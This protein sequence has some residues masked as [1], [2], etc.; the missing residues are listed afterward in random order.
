MLVYTPHSR[1]AREA[2]QYAG[3]KAAPR[4]IKNCDREV[5]Q[6]NDIPQHAYNNLRAL[7]ENLC[8]LGG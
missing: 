3:M 4:Q 5:G 6:V 7:R 2:K 8:A 1:S